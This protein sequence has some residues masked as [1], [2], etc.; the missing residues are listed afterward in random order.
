MPPPPCYVCGHPRSTYYLERWWDP[1]PEPWDKPNIRAYYC[2]ACMPPPAAWPS[3]FGPGPYRLV[4]RRGA[5][6]LPPAGTANEAPPREGD[7]RGGPGGP[8]SAKERST[9]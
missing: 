9:R 2:A 3:R 1:T 6:A 8:P 7:G 5:P 4:P